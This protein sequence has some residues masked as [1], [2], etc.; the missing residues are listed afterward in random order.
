VLENFNRTGKFSLKS[1]DFLP[2]ALSTRAAEFKPAAIL[3]LL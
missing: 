2:L 3:T 1:Y